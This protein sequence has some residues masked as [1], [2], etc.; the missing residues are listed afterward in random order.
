MQVIDSAEAT[1]DAAVRL[2]GQDARENAAARTAAARFG[3]LPQ[4]RWT[5]L[6]GWDRGFWAG[7]RAKWNW[8]IWAADTVFGCY[9]KNGWPAS[10]AQRAAEEESKH[11]Q[12]GG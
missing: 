7:P 5:S 11:D 12:S 2:F 1:A 4:T 10:P 6:S 9:P 3:V 8:W